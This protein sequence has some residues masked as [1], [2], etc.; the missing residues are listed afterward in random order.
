VWEEMLHFTRERE[1]ERGG[2]KRKDGV[3]REND[4]EEPHR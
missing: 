1:R 3:C 2:K 4:E